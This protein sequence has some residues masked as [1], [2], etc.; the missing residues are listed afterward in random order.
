MKTWSG[1]ACTPCPYESK[2]DSTRHCSELCS[3]EDGEE[4]QSLW[5]LRLRERDGGTE[6]GATRLFPAMTCPLLSAGR[7][8]IWG[9]T[10]V[11]VS[12]KQVTSRGQRGQASRD[13]GQQW[14]VWQTLNMGLQFL[15]DLGDPSKLLFIFLRRQREAMRLSP[16]VLMARLREPIEI[17]SASCSTF[18]P[19]DH[20]SPLQPNYSV[21]VLKRKKTR[22]KKGKQSSITA[23]VN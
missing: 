17:L 4:D 8:G 16:C 20:P 19:A 7:D 14:E 23:T 18:L 1:R 11:L 9:M 5:F 2:L 3:R 13:V 12:W 10:P 15:A 6:P 22:H 21:W